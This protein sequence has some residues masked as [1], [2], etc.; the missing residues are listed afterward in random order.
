V[1]QQAAGGLEAMMKVNWV[2]YEGVWGVSQEEQEA[3]EY[4]RY[5]ARKVDVSGD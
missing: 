5:Q 2:E 1:A 4:R 3:K